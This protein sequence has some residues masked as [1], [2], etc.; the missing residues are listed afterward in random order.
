M[1]AITS[2]QDIA[3][4]VRVTQQVTFQDGQAF[5]GKVS[6]QTLVWRVDLVI[7]E[8]FEGDGV[9]PV[10][11]VGDESDPEGWISAGDVD[12]GQV[13]VYPSGEWVPYRRGKYYPVQERVYVTVEDQ[14][15][16]CAGACH[17]VL[18]CVSL[19]GLVS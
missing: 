4:Y 7:T 16:L 5:V 11:T 10:I 9:L 1:T 12:A 19:A 13:G 3:G 2:K 14:E 18:H 8:P 17:A 15:Q 6:E